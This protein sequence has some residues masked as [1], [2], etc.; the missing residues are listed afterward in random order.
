MSG[1]QGSSSSQG[2]GLL[3]CL[4]SPPPPWRARPAAERL[5]FGAQISV[6]GHAPVPVGGIE[7]LVEPPAD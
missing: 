6:V 4:R 3:Q 1:G 7:S 2:S 5:G